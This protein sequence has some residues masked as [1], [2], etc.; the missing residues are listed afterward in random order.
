MRL[1]RPHASGCPATHA[2]GRVRRPLRERADPALL[3]PGASKSAN[4]FFF[5]ETGHLPP[6]CCTKTAEKNGSKTRSINYSNLHII[7]ICAY[8]LPI[9]RNALPFRADPFF[10]G[11]TAQRNAQVARFRPK[12]TEPNLE[13]RSQPEHGKAPA[14]VHREPP[15]IFWTCISVS[16]KMGG[17][18]QRLDA[19][20]AVR[21]ERAATA[22]RARAA[23]A[24]AAGAAAHGA[25]A[26]GGAGRPASAWRSTG[27]PSTRDRAR[28][29]RWGT[30]SSGA[31]DSSGTG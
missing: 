28:D 24:V 23:A 20:A 16:K 14:S 18:S 21:N 1:T 27:T 9:A 12:S 10:F 15:P 26:G 5:A 11:K 17:G 8:A 31:D 25:G 3:P 4:P 29:G 19:G 22:R 7:A 30:C 13:A 2:R 6:S